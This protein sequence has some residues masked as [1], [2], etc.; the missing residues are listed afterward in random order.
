MRLVALAAAVFVSALALSIFS[1][2]IA[3]EAADN[4]NNG[5]KESKS[6]VVKSG[7]TLDGI[8][9]GHSTT[10]LRLYYANKSIENPDLI[11]P[12]DKIRIP[13]EDEKLKKRSLPGN[14]PANQQYQPAAATSA[15]QVSAQPRQAEPA[16]APT[17]SGGVWDRLAQCES[18]GNWSINTGNGYYGGLQFSLSSWQAVGGQGYPHQASKSEQIARAEQLLAIQGWGAWPAC[19]SALGLR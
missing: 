17:V 12:G 3:V 13:A 16:P 5:S 10:Y 11:Y 9:K 19:S 4:K 8:A 2:P 7:D 6:V 1:S 15:P 14:Q 18:G